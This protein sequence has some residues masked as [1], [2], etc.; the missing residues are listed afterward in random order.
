M[1]YD[2]VAILVSEDGARDLGRMLPG[3]RFVADA[4]GHAKFAGWGPEAR[5]LFEAAGVDPDCAGVVPLD[6]PGAAAP[7]IENCAALRVR[8]RAG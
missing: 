7:F 3:R 8:D 4:V 5:A 6:R 1:L 2:A